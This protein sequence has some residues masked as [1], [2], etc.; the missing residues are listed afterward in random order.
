MG[1]II[2]AAVC[3]LC[4]AL[5]GF[6]ILPTLLGMLWAI[7]VNAFFGALIGF[8]IGSG[9]GIVKGGGGGMS[10]AKAG[11]LIGLTIEAL[12]SLVGGLLTVA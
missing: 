12:A 8:W 11:S 1:K 2:G 5:L 6:A 7:F 10:G 4:I 9:L 3:M